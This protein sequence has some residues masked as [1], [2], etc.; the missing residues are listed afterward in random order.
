MRVM[1]S[2]HDTTE[3][4]ITTVKN[5]YG[6]YEYGVSFENR[7][8]ISIIA[9]YDNFDN[10][11]TVYVRAVAQSLPH[12]GDHSRDSASPHKPTLGAPFEMRPPPHSAAQSPSRS[13]ARSA[14]IR[15]MSPHSD[16]G[17]RSA[18]AA[19]GNKARLQKSKSKDNSVMGDHEGY[20][21][22]INDNGSIASSRRS[23]AE[24][25]KAEITV[26]NIVEGGR[27]KRAFESS[28]R[29]IMRH[30]LRLS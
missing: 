7:D 9:A 10:D 27:R 4:I 22:D 12:V 3:S 28:V 18:S 2:P 30:L 5:F 17:H 29:R 14:G 8:G 1:I 23:K 20:S 25:I 13:A 19:P 16:S 24:E 15:S 26:D 11:M 21:S 6:V